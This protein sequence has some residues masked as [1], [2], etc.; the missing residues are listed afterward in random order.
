MPP[1][2]G[3]SISII[4][5]IITA[6]ARDRLTFIFLEN[7]FCYQVEISVGEGNGT[8]LQYSC[9]HNPRDGG[10]WWAAIYGV[11]QGRTQL[12][13][14]S[15]LAETSVTRHKIHSSW[16]HSRFLYRVTCMF[17]PIRKKNKEKTS[18]RNLL[19]SSLCFPVDCI[20]QN[21]FATLQLNSVI[22]CAFSNKKLRLGLPGWYSG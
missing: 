14:L 18:P 21:W 16:L 6:K 12:K 4:A 19:L 20:Y 5:L 1:G 22:T 9:L 7:L 15:S 13:W 3:F 17:F 10:A 11:T 2:I 8:P